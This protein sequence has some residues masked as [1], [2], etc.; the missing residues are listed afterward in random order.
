M[1]KNRPPAQKVREQRAQEVAIHGEN[2]CR[3][4]LLNRF[5]DVAKAFFIDETAP[6]FAD[7][8]RALAASRKAYKVVDEVELERITGSCHHGG[9]SLVVKKPP[10]ISALGGAFWCAGTDSARSRFTLFGSSRACGRRWCRGALS[11][12][13]SRFCA[14]I[15]A[16]S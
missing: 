7:A 13:R 4:A 10:V 6:R 9:V 1:T 2:A 14:R 16:I 12:Q 5:D 8:M 15:V 3:A 11:H